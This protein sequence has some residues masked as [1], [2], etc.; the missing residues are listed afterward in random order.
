MGFSI[1][2]SVPVS[3]RGISCLAWGLGFGFSVQA[4]MGVHM[5]RTVSAR[6]SAHAVVVY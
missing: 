3:V 4:W 1:A 6:R 2:A 5:C